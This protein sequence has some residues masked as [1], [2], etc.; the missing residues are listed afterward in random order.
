MIKAVNS[1]A[2]RAD[3]RF[4]FD[5]NNNIYLLNKQDGLIRR[6]TEAGHLS[7]FTGEVALSNGVD[8]LAFANG[9]YFGYYSFLSNPNYLYH[10]DLGYEYIFDAADGHSGVYLYD[11]KSGTFF[12][13]S[14]TFP[15][16]YLYDFKLNTVLYYYPDKNNPGH[17]NTGGVR[18]FYDF[19]TGTIISK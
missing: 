1:S 8:Y 2:T 13:T 19:A 12:Y 7:F 18:Y 17:Y 4:G 16:P 14:P 3:L 5:A 15:F 9:G 6:I 10:S 11:F